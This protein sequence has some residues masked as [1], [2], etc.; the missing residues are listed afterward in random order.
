M[1]N[2]AHTIISLKQILSYLCGSIGN[3]FHQYHL[4]ELASFKKKL[5]TSTG[6][7]GVHL[8]CVHDL[9]KRD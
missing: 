8:Q 1:G 5:R 6:D 9:D 7:A 4:T 3:V 2:R